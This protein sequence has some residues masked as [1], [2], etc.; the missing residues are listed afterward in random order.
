[1]NV[2]EMKIIAAENGFTSKTKLIEERCPQDFGYID[3]AEVE[4]GKCCNYPGGYNKKVCTQCWKDAVSPEDISAN[5]AEE[6]DDTVYRLTRKA[7]ETDGQ[8]EEYIKACR[9]ADSEA[10]QV[11]HPSHYSQ[12]GR[13][14]CIEEMRLM[15]GDEKV[16][17]WCVMTAYKY[18]YR[19]G[20]KDGNPSEQDE[21]KAEW[22]LDYAE[23]MQKVR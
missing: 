22:Y 20:N 3:Y 4:N 16:Y 8:Y 9:K 17:W 21:R 2:Q 14:E 10:E 23:G 1:M 15:F 5:I 11:N 6:S 12:A 18:R 13:R 7:F 19:M